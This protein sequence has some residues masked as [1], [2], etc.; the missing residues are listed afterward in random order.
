MLKRIYGA[1]LIL[2]LGLMTANELDAEQ[3]QVI[4]EQTLEEFAKIIF[5]KSMEAKRA[6][7]TTQVREEVIDNFATTAPRRDT[8]AQQS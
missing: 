1:I 4:K 3:Q 5:A 7:Q 2:V 6:F 8:T